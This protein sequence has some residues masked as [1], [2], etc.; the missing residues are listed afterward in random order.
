MKYTTKR[1]RRDTKHTRTKKQTVPVCHSDREE[2]RKGSRENGEVR[3]AVLSIP[4]TLFRWS[5][6]VNGS[7]IHK[8]FGGTEG[9][10][11]GVGG[12]E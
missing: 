2:Q 1:E 5:I 12:G 6:S 4:S 11:G 7:P 8:T 9:E 3:R 10:R